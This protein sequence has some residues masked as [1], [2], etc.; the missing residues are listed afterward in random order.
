MAFCGGPLLSTCLDDLHKGTQSSFLS[1]NNQP[2][3][4][5]D[6]IAQAVTNNPNV[7]TGVNQDIEIV[8]SPLPQ[9]ILVIAL[10]VEQEDRVIVGVNNKSDNIETSVL[11][12][13]AVPEDREIVTAVNPNFEVLAAPVETVTLEN[14]EPKV[15]VAVNPIKVEAGVLNKAD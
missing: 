9:D 13:V 10:P 11:N 14:G 4:S 5:T 2:L 12:L 1:K 7:V 6:V 15:I 3:N 8:A